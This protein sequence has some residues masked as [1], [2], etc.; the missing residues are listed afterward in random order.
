MTNPYFLCK[1]IQN[2]ATQSDNSDS[3]DGLSDY[4]D[5]TIACA[6]S[7][8][9]EERNDAF[10]KMLGP[11]EYA[12]SKRYRYALERYAFWVI[13]NKDVYS[14]EDMYKACDCLLMAY[15][16]RVDS[17]FDYI[18]EEFD[19]TVSTEL[20]E[21]IRM[22]THVERKMWLHGKYESMND[23]PTC[24]KH[25]IELLYNCIQPRKLLK[26]TIED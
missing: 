8:F 11:L 16:R 25:A 4:S 23:Y 26:S 24:I 21:A 9:I 3:C 12:V 22:A 14:K 2:M 10:D 18:N 19:A 17:A 5:E 13:N 20:T 6:N 1:L 7:C 15:Y